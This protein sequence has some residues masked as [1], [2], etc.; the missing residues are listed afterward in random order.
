MHSGRIYF[1]VDE[2]EIFL[3]NE[4]LNRWKEKTLQHN[5][6]RRGVTLRK[7]NPIILRQTTTKNRKKIKK[8]KLSVS[9][10]KPST[11]IPTLSTSHAGMRHYKPIKSVIEDTKVLR[12][13]LKKPRTSNN[14]SID[15]HLENLRREEELKESGFFHRSLSAIS[16]GDNIPFEKKTEKEEEKSVTEFM[17]AMSKIFGQNYV[18][19]GDYEYGKKFE[20]NHVDKFDK[21][22]ILAKNSINITNSVA[23]ASFSDRYNRDSLKL[24][25]N[26]VKKK[27]ELKQV[28]HTQAGYRLFRKDFYVEAPELTL[29]DDANITNIRRKMDIK[30]KGKNCPCPISTWNQ[31]G[32]SGVM[33]HAL[34]ENNFPKPFAIQRQAIP[35]IM[36]GRDVIG[37]AKT[38]S[39]KTL[40][41]LL[42][43]F[44]HIRHQQLPSHI[45]G[46]IGLIMAPAR[47]LAVQIYKQALLFSKVLKL[48]VT[49]VYGGASIKEQIASIKRGCEIVVGTPGRIIDVL[50]LNNGRLLTLKHVTYV[51]LDEA[52]RMFDM[53]FEPQ[54]SSILNNIRPDRQ[55]LLFSATFPQKVE[56]LARNVLRSP[57]E[58][59]LG[60]RSVASDTITQVVE[61]LD[62][63]KECFLRLLKIL[64]IWH[65]EGSNILVFVDTQKRCDELFH[66]LGKYGYE[67]LSLHGGKEQIDR[68]YVIKDFNNKVR[69]IMVATSVAGRGLDV[70]DLALV[71]NFSCPNHMEDYVHRIGRT[72]RAGNN[73]TAY[74]FVTPKDEQYAHDIGKALRKSNVPLPAK[75]QRMIQQF[76]EKVERGEANYKLNQYYTVKGYTFDPSEMTEQQRRS[77]MDQLQFMNE[78]G[79][80]LTKEDRDEVELQHK[81]L[82][83]FM[84]NT[85]G[86]SNFYGSKI[87]K[88]DMPRKT[89][90]DKITDARLLKAI[91]VAK[92]IS[93]TNA[94]VEAAVNVNGTKQ[95]SGSG[96][97]GQ[98]LQEEYEAKMDIS[99]YPR[100]VIKVVLDK[101]TRIKIADLTDGATFTARGK[102][103]S[104]GQK[105]S[106]GEEPLHLIIEAN[107]EIKVK[108]CVKEIN[109]LL[110]QS[111]L[112]LYGGGK[113]SMIKYG[114]YCL[115]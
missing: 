38:G 57:I 68:D 82:L 90:V 89:P 69:T 115:L 15:D 33:I 78:S 36:K 106:I 99:G 94:A 46:P 20:V 75:L 84:N 110:H 42:P 81:A 80:A 61:V 22:H 35:A 88:N 52:D 55:T 11:V 95:Y 74:T 12:N 62:D 76:H 10:L 21:D 103:L 108:A 9:S 97:K 4:R 6:Q 2:R 25:K 34:T 114:D 105:I 3:R 14:A 49:C 92:S 1:Q 59:S 40:A 48:R 102:F 51:V 19:N 70:S 93:E 45:R 27:K 112:K 28:D 113:S 104:S 39:G 5:Q 13:S 79:I 111:T 67:A 96:S 32:M 47:E 29:I 30:I 17:V 8:R 66:E 54:I 87:T 37:I 91:K 77:K 85:N 109:R 98:N 58:I 100:E 7:G 44:R 50:C 86:N 24:L 43:L 41:F 60:G 23:A 71:I 56:A 101:K 64:G 18:N 63:E 73:G 31:A 107:T 72:G 53:G 16:S 83:G 26:Q 65:N